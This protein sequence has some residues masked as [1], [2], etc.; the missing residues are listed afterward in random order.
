MATLKRNKLV[1][2]LLRY[3]PFRQ[4]KILFASMVLRRAWVKFF[5]NTRLN[6]RYW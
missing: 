3:L 5:W 4:V 6:R 2:I 1:Y